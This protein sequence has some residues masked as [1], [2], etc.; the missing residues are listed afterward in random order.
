MG[1][2]SAPTK[3]T[4]RQTLLLGVYLIVTFLVQILVLVDF[5]PEVQTGGTWKQG[6][7]CL[8]SQP[9][10]IAD[11]ARSFVIVLL[12]GGIGAMVHSLRSFTAHVGTQKIAASW[13]WW[14]LLRPLEGAVMALAFYLALRGGL[15]GTGGTGA[16]GS[17]SISIYG[18]AGISVLV[19][20]FSHEAAQKLKELAETLFSKAPQAPGSA[21]NQMAHRTPSLTSVTPAEIN[22][23][24]GSATIDV[25]GR[26]F[27]EK[28]EVRIGGT[29][30]P[31]VYKSG[32]EL[33]ASLTSDDTKAAGA[34]KL[35]VFTPPPGGGE[36][37]PPVELQVVQQ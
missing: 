32:T 25:V 24:V 21:A 35:T 1:D 10:T 7:N 31:T 13:V 5:W 2:N 33:S 9:C 34:L 12:G 27:S 37:Q 3:M 20:M 17:T 6:W 15:Q 28:S 4:F 19:G 36:S 26:D 22:I 11:D 16:S 30:R 8:T 29:G 18:V 14:Y 23:G